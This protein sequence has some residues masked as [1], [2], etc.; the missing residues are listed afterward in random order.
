MGVCCNKAKQEETAS[1]IPKTLS[2]KPSLS[3]SPKKSMVEVSDDNEFT[4][5]LDEELMESPKM[6]LSFSAPTIKLHPVEIKS[7]DLFGA[8]A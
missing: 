8:K 2:I 7:I 3:I 1:V 5:S 6:K 4:E